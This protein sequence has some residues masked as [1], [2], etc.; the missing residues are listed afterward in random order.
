[1][2]A[3]SSFDSA[4]VSCDKTEKAKGRGCAS[5]RTGTEFQIQKMAPI[6]GGMA[7]SSLAFARFVTL[8][9]SFPWNE[10]LCAA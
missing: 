3:R 7:D 10:T 4:C 6:L 9:F 5:K 2:R 8:Y 1:M